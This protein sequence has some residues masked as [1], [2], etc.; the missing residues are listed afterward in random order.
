MSKLFW[1][2]S[3][4]NASKEQG[5]TVVVHEYDMNIVITVLKWPLMN[6]SRNVTA[7]LPG[8][9]RNFSLLSLRKNLFLYSYA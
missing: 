7:A 5:S 6:S 8:L 1:G 3:F 4:W 9:L 2:V